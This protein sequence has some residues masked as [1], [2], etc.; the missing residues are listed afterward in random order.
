MTS[1]MSQG[2]GAITMQVKMA[3]FEM[4][5]SRNAI[6]VV[7]RQILGVYQHASYDNLACPKYSRA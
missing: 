1:K 5:S 6:H 7:L 3:R 4:S 2:I